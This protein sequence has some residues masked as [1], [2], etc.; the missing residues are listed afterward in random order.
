MD[1]RHTRSHSWVAP[2]APPGA[3]LWHIPPSFTGS[4]DG[5]QSG[6][7]MEKTHLH[8][9]QQEAIPLQPGLPAGAREAWSPQQVFP[10]LL[11][12]ARHSDHT[13]R[14]H[15]LYNKC[16]MG[17]LTIFTGS[18]VEDQRGKASCPRSG[19]RAAGAHT[20]EHS[21]RREALICG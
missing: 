21:Q 3:C 8:A 12:D 5:R 15:I 1:Q 2:W 17:L 13:A 6:L 11:L 9:V 14:P 16:R 18:R 19:H 20:A 10:K 4:L 7:Y